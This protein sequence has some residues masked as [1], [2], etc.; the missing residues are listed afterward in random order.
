MYIYIYMY[1]YVY[2]PFIYFN[3]LFFW[4]KKHHRKQVEVLSYTASKS[5]GKGRFLNVL[6]MTK[7]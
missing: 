1:I 5:R 2:F 7:V 6:Q 4:R 3:L